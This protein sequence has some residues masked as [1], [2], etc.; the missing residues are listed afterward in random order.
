MATQPS[1]TKQAA[2]SAEQA[3]TT[4]ATPV[5]K[6]VDVT[7]PAKSAATNVASSTSDQAKDKKAASQALASSEEKTVQSAKKDQNEQTL[8]ISQ[9]TTPA[10]ADQVKEDKTTAVTHEA[11]EVNLYL[12]ADDGNTMGEFQSGQTMWNGGWVRFGVAGTFVVPKSAIK[13]GNQ[14]KLLVVNQTSSTDWLSSFCWEWLT[15]VTI[16]GKKLGTL[17]SSPAQLYMPDKSIT[18]YLTLSD[19]VEQEFGDKSDQFVKM[20]VS[21]AGVFGYHSDILP[22]GNMKDHTSVNTYTIANGAHKGK[23]YQVIYK[24]G[25][26]VHNIRKGETTNV[27]TTHNTGA[28]GFDSTGSTNFDPNPNTTALDAEGR[29]D[30]TDSL[31]SDYHVNPDYQLPVVAVNI[32]NDKGPVGFMSEPNNIWTQG[33]SIPFVGSDG[34]TKNT[35]LALDDVTI[36]AANIY[37]NAGNDKS[38][39]YLLSQNFNGAIYSEQSD[40]SLS[41]VVR[42]KA[43]NFKITNFGINLDGSFVSGGLADRWLHNNAAVA[44]DP[45]PKQAIINTINAF[46]K[47]GSIQTNINPFI[48]VGVKSQKEPG[49]TTTKFYDEQGNYVSEQTIN[50]AAKSFAIEGQT[51]IK[52]NYINGLT[53]ETIKSESHMGWPANNNH[54]HAQDQ[55]D[56][57]SLSDYNR[58]GYTYRQDNN[59]QRLTDNTD[60]VKSNQTNTS[61]VNG[62]DTV[63]VHGNSQQLSY[64]DS[65][66]GS[67]TTANYDYILDPNPQK[68]TVNYKDLDEGGKSLQSDNLNG[69]S[70]MTANYSTKESIDKYSKQGYRVKGDDTNGNKPVFDANDDVDQTFTVTF[71]HQKYTVT[72]DQ[73]K[74]T[75]DNLPDNPTVHFPGGVDH[76][77]LN[78]TVT[79]TIN[80]TSPDGKT[81]TQRQTVTFTR[82]ATVDE[83][84]SKVTYGGWSENGHHQFGK[85]DV[86]EI[87]GYTAQGA[88]TAITV[89]PNSQ[90]STVNIIYTPNKQTG[91]ISYVGPDGKEVTSTPLNGNND[92]EI[93]IT[94]QIPAGWEEVPGQQIPATETAT[95]DGIPTVI[96]KIQHKKITVQPGET[97]PTGKVP[98]NSDKNYPAMDSLTSAPT[99]TITVTDPQG[100]KTTIKQSVE[101]TR[102]ATFDE[103]T[104]EVT[105]T[106]WTMQSSTSSAHPGDQWDAYVAPEFTGYHA[107]QP[108]PRVK[109]NADTESTTVDITYAPND[110]VATVNY[111]DDDTDA[112]SKGHIIKT[113][114]IKGQYG[115]TIKFNND[116]TI[117]DLIKKHYSLVG[118]LTPKK[119]SSDSSVMPLSLDPSDDTYTFDADDNNNVFEIHF[120]HAHTYPTRDNTV[121]MTVHYVDENGHQLAPEKVQTVTFTDTG[122]QDLVTNKTKWDYSKSWMQSQ[123][124]A[125][126]DSPS[127][128]GYTPD[129]SVVKG[130]SVTVYHAPVEVTVHYRANAEQVTVRYEDQNGHEIAPADTLSGKFGDHYTTSAKQIAG[131]KLVQTP[132][133]ANGMYA[134][135]N[136][137]VVYIYRADAQPQ[138]DNG[139]K[140]TTP[141]ETPATK[142]GEH[143]TP[144]TTTTPSTPS[145]PSTSTTKTTTTTPSTDPQPRDQHNGQTPAA[146]AT[147]VNGRHSTAQPV[148]GV[149]STPVT[150]RGS[151]GDRQSTNQSQLPQ[152]G[153]QTS[154]GALV[155]MGMAS[156]LGMLGLAAHDKKR[157]TK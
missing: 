52:I 129:Q 7:T 46:K 136:D 11:T 92:Q 120:K 157:Q 64:P 103:V 95:A 130:Q 9:S 29:K 154:R 65:K 139:G 132:A 105:Y 36:P 23:S 127:I 85:V 33:S 24:L 82:N 19:N 86:P 107:S 149:D 62:S 146:P 13:N 14:I 135:N 37:K 58:P 40:G 126:V 55:F 21:H 80:I 91:K 77:S 74:T 63:L 1:T 17:T 47:A 71:T 152:T 5:K 34:K 8:K 87:P 109:V 147:P 116:Q 112:K 12:R 51:T 68:M 114:T 66:T 134:E 83:V 54:G 70:D 32:K 75:K 61:L 102:T 140:S 10:T 16:D 118:K 96:I 123:R 67:D 49:A 22:L 117:N 111:I 156:V 27:T 35:L 79:R 89:T 137:D 145:T 44:F 26:D 72:P 133:N 131:Y 50:D 142:P 18:L 25:E 124:F 76:D 88:V 125:D 30:Y 153:N 6:S 143:Q 53:G 148:Q 31:G 73:P 150:D 155:G 4:K 110:Q 41:I 122:D 141:G 60:D 121:L 98:G 94:P 3:N 15:D 69:Y 43:G 59:S 128:P 45:N 104:G 20:N 84:T 90:D 100:H 138:S 101:F 48:G 119:S 28:V 57:G 93:T 42:Y 78:K 97:A 56:T 99:R 113:D 38:I 144:G 115:Q 106:D 108:V 2:D 151:K 39:K 81:T